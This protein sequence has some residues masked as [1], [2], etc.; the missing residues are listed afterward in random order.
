[1]SD[2]KIIYKF[3]KNHDEEIRVSIS[4]YGGRDLID[5][6]A[7]VEKEGGHAEFIPTRKGLTLNVYVF[8]E[9][10]RAIEKLEAVLVGEGLLDAACLE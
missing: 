7:F 9:L 6:R 4:K 5:I 1:M 8:P 3:R 10:K 2:P